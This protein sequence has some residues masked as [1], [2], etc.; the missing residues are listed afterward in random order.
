MGNEPDKPFH[1]GDYLL[2]VASTKDGKKSL[3]F[4]LIDYRADDAREHYVIDSWQ[5]FDLTALGEVE[6]VRFSMKGSRQ[7]NGGTTIPAYFCLDNFG[8]EVIATESAPLTLAVKGQSTQDVSKL[9][10]DAGLLKQT[11]PSHGSSGGRSPGAHRGIGWREAPASS[12]SSGRSLRIPPSTHR[13]HGDS[14]S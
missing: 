10:T 11:T 3:E 5:W 7:A 6:E 4:P 2:L 9:F 8:G 1:K 13:S 14:Y 12:S